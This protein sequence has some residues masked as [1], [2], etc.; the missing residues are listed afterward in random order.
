MNRRS[1][2][3]KVLRR[4]LQIGFV[5]LISV[6][7]SST[8]YSQST[9]ISGTI[10][11][12]ETK[13]PLA[14]ST[15]S[16]VNY[17][18]GAVSNFLGEFTFTIPDG[19]PSDKLVISMLGYH[20]REISVSSFS[21]NAGLVVE[22]EPEVILLSE[23]QISAEQLSADQIV[24]R[25]VE[26]IQK[27]YPTSPYL[28]EGFTRA[29][30]YECGQYAWLYEG[31]FELYGLG[32][33]KKSPERV[34]MK[35]SRQTL[36]VED[37]RSQ[38]L[39]MNRNPFISMSHINDV[40]FRSYSLKTRGK[41]YELSNYTMLDDQLVYVV[42]TSHSRYEEHKMYIDINDFGLLKVEMKMKTPTDEDGN[43]LLNKGT[44]NDSL[45]FKVTEISKTI[46]F[47][48]SGDKYYP[49]YMDWL[50]AGVLTDKDTNHEV[51]D[52]GFRFETMYYDVT[53]DNV[54]KPSNG[55]LMRPRGGKDPEPSPY[56]PEFWSEY[57]LLKEFPITPQI[58]KDLEK[59]GGLGEQFKLIR[60]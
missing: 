6:V 43:P 28:L 4:G 37:Y 42:K 25:V 59:N 54:K 23:I 7:L 34:Y 1:A 49:K 33:Q 44:S 36:P 57:P 47:E 45:D 51:C 3:Y 15:I 16:T 39:R 46:Q 26:N 58:V 24:Q 12:A 10:M 22:L 40:M 8:C 35:A 29:H 60:K 27:N 13:E 21:I 53:T 9:V 52:W 14:F 5:Y 32:Y 11:D 20:T 38:V 31:V 30:K 18:S 48:K 19:L 55:N 50:V 2:S 56:H 17:T 41:E